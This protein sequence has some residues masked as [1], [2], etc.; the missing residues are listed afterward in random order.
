MMN[1]Y[2]ADTLLN[3]CLFKSCTEYLFSFCFFV[4]SFDDSSVSSSSMSRSE[5]SDK[6]EEVVSVDMN[7]PILG[8]DIPPSI[9]SAGT[10]ITKARS[11]GNKQM[12]V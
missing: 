1:T 6:D 2:I 3:I 11:Q 10:T 5:A 9:S 4:Q 7:N 8:L 12:F